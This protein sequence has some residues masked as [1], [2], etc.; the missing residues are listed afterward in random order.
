MLMS[1]SLHLRTLASSADVSDP[2]AYQCLLSSVAFHGGVL[3]MISSLF[4]FC[5][6]SLSSVIAAC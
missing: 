3:L 1:T 2:S 6:F 5:T 4:V